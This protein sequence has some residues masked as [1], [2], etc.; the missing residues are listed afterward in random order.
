MTATSQSG[1]SEASRT[2]STSDDR[3]DVSFVDDVRA[4]D[5][6]AIRDFAGI[7]EHCEQREAKRTHP[8]CTSDVAPACPRTGR[9]A[10]TVVPP[11]GDMRFDRRPPVRQLTWSCGVRDR[12][13]DVSFGRLGATRRVVASAT[14]RWPAIGLREPLNSAAA[15]TRLNRLCFCKWLAPHALAWALVPAKVGF[16]HHRVG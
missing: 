12:A 1:R 4:L 11:S 15:P 13:S 3:G 2:R 10:T 6:E 5:E 9:T 7:S 16:A 8:A 14:F